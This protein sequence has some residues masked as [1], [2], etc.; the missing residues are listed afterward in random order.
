M[1][2][3]V[4]PPDSSLWVPVVGEQGY[5]YIL[6]LYEATIGDN[7]SVPEL[8]AINTFETSSIMPRINALID[9]VD[10]LEAEIKTMRATNQ[11]LMHELSK[12]I[13]TVDY[14]FMQNNALAAQ[15]NG[16]I[17]HLEDIESMAYVN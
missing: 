7:G 17:D 6:D 3:V 1:T 11:S 8:E 13:T 5:Q 10:E 12:K 2:H 16:L 14:L 15:V 4:A 9:K